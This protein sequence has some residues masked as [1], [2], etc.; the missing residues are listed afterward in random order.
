MQ[1]DQQTAQAEDPNVSDKTQA[2]AELVEKPLSEEEKKKRQE[3]KKMRDERVKECAVKIQE[4][5]SKYDCTMDSK[6]ILLGSGKLLGEV[7]ISSK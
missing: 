4:I 7:V 3:I 5:L 1:T 2:T 6:I